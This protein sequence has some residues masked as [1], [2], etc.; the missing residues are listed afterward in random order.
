MFYC[1][2]LSHEPTS[3]CCAARGYAY[4]TRIDRSNFTLGLLRS[5][6]GNLKDVSS[7][8]EV[9][10]LPFE[11]PYILSDL[12]KCQ[13]WHVAVG[14][15]CGVGKR[16][17][18]GAATWAPQW[19]QALDVLITALELGPPCAKH[20]SAG[21]ADISAQASYTDVIGRLVSTIAYGD[22][23]DL[24]RQL[25]LEGGARYA[26]LPA[27]VKLV[28]ALRQKGAAP[29]VAAVAA[30]QLGDR[31]MAECFALNRQLLAAE[32]L[33]AEPTAVA[34]TSASIH[35]MSQGRVSPRLVASA[36]AGLHSASVV[37]ID[38]EWPPHWTEKQAR[39]SGTQPLAALLQLALVGCGHSLMLSLRQ[40]HAVDPATDKVCLLLS[41]CCVIL[42]G[43]QRW[44]S[45]HDRLAA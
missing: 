16:G 7:L 33:L 22:R 43:Q 20:T 39:L 19:T 36:I 38:A 11:P 8:V 21:H 35:F 14:Y 30:E 10:E 4:R 42:Q 25:S 32:S 34:I 27:Q 3:S 1:F 37:A 26:S 9:L 23:L 18:A 5:K 41:I 12:C 17:G 24:L 15:A 44:R 28:E 6:S 2:L 40:R 13:R 29:L 31:C 45:D